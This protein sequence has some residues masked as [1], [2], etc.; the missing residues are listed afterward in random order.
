MPAINID[1]MLAGYI[2]CALWS[3]T[4]DNNTPL[5]SNFSDVDI[6]KTSIGE[7]RIDCAGFIQDATHAGI[8]LETLDM[9]SGSIGHDLWLTRNGHGAGFWDRGLGKVGDELSVIAKV[10]GSVDPMVGDDGQI[11][12]Y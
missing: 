11:Y 5:D 10:M 9:D 8:N 6:H 12:F 3:S 1:A 2:E 7:A 4:D